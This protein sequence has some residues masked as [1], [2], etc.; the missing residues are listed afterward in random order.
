M[1]NKDNDEGTA[2]ARLEQVL[3]AIKNQDKE[4]VESIFSKQAM[5][6]ADDFDSSIDAL[7]AF[8]QGEVDSWEK[9]SGPTVFESNDHGHVTKKVSS[10]YYVT[11]DKQKPSKNTSFY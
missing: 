10:Y 1:L 2:N 11:T 9:S 5:D 8:F 4:A 3:D 6:D 7:F